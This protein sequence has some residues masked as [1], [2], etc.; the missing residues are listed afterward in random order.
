VGAL[1]QE[2]F[3]DVCQ[4]QN[5]V[6]FIANGRLLQDDLRVHECGLGREAHI[7]VSISTRADA[8]TAVPSVPGCPRAKQSNMDQIGSTI[9]DG[10]SAR[11]VLFAICVAA[12]AVVLRTAWVKRRSLALHLSQLLYISIAC[13][14]YVVIAHVLPPMLSFAR[15]SLCVAAAERWRTGASR[16]TASQFG[17]AVI[18]AAADLRTAVSLPAAGPEPSQLL[19]TPT[20]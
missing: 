9:V 7:H 4:G 14:A 5:S 19:T 13:W 11:Q 1:K 8:T 16:V 15:R 6:R 20:L 12:S 10:L 2:I 18:E 17:V 3:P